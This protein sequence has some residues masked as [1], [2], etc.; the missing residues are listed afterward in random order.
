[1]DTKVEVLLGQRSFHRFPNVKVMINNSR[2]QELIIKEDT[3]VK[4]NLD[5]PRDSKLTLTIEHY[6]K[7]D[8]DCV[9]EK[10]LDTAVLIKSIRLNGIVDQKFIWQGVFKPN[11]PEHY[12]PK[13]PELYNNDY[14]GFNGVWTL[15][16]TVPLFTWIHQTLD[17]GWIYD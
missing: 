2:P 6:G 12:E 9:P 4:F 13:T 15:K 7:T 5:L 14:L 1:M 3:W 17:L 10:D 8:Q 16:M 11:Y